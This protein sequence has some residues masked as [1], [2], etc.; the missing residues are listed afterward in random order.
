MTAGRKKGFKFN[1]D[2]DGNLLKKDGTPAKKPGRKP[3]RPKKP[4]DANKQ[5]ISKQFANDPSVS[6]IKEKTLQVMD[7]ILLQLN[8]NQSISNKKIIELKEKATIANIIY[9]SLT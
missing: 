9:S 8:S 4:A 1:R 3:K 5:F 2:D 7:R 6:N